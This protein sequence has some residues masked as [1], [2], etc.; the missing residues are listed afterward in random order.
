MR[1][2]NPNFLRMKMELKDRYR[3]DWMVKPALERMPKRKKHY[4]RR[5]WNWM[6][7]KLLN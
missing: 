5:I 1:F 6:L 7:C 4:L 2:S 3:A